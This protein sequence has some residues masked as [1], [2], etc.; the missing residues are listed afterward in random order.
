MALLGLM[1]A[2]AFGAAVLQ[3]VPYARIVSGVQIQGDA[4]TWWDKAESRYRRGQTPKK[5]AVLA[6]RPNG[7][8][9]LGHVA[10]VSRVLDDR[11]ILIRHAN[12]SVP[13]AIE[14]DVLTIDVSDRGDWSAVRVWF[15]PGDR[16]GARI[17]PTF[18]F[19]YPDKAKLH[20]FRPDPALGASTQFARI[21]D[22]RWDQEALPS[23]MRAPSPRVRSAMT[24]KTQPGLAPVQMAQATTTRRAPDQHR[25]RAV[26]QASFIVEYPDASGRGSANL[27]ADRTLSDIIADVKRDAAIR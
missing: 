1:S 16:I 7:P 10:V 25:R 8:M 26:R 3:C 14:E 24:S 21:D 17:N 12:W 15:S 5:G 13:G 20:K 9:A 27:S 2:P 11:R 4:L 19:I 18:G 6:F 23:R 22:D